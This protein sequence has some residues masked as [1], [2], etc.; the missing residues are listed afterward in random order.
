MLH[1]S[2][3]HSFFKYSKMKHNEVKQSY[4]F[5]AGQDKLTRKR[6]QGMAQELETHLMSLISW[7]SGVP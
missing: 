2:I 7:H 6:A 5:R 4:H 1:I 3:N